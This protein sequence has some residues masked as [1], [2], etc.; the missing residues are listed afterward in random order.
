A[1]ARYRHFRSFLVRDPRSRP[2]ADWRHAPSFVFIYKRGHDIAA[3]PTPE[4][5]PCMPEF[6]AF[7]SHLN[8]NPWLTGQNE[9]SGLKRVI[10]VGLA[11]LFAG[12]ASAQELKSPRISVAKV[13]WD[14]A[15]AGIVDRP[16]GAPA[17]AF[18]K[19]NAA[20]GVSFPSID[21]SSVP[22]LLPY[23]VDALIKDR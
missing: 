3:H 11:L 1:G 15:A 9:G 23:D 10:L 4:S 13:D 18:A 8:V 21:G 12:L 5:S 20:A 16:A 6:D 17:E 14:A 19:L 7:N 2:E 22:V